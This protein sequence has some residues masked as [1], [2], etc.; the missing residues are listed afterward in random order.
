MA[1]KVLPAAV[2]TDPERLKRFEREAGKGQ[3]QSKS[4]GKGGKK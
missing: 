3:S 4:K 2:V 1:I